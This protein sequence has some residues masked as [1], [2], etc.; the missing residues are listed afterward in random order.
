MKSQ[1]KKIFDQQALLNDEEWELFSQHL[2][3][4][5]FEKGEVILDQ[6]Q[7]E[8]Y[9][10]F[11][12]HGTARMFTVDEF[13]NEFS[14]EFP[15]DNCFCCSYGSFVTQR[16]SMI[17]VEALEPIKAYRISYKDLQF[18]YNK[19][20]TGERLGRINAE[21]FL[22]HK[23]QREIML[24]TLNAKQRY[25][26]LINNNPKILRLVKLEHIATYLGITPQSLSRIRNNIRI[27]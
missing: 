2:S 16:P 18:L 22:A 7:I 1:I 15:S 26:S 6:G 12:I 19:S 8:Q 24:L 14:I 9:L 4:A 10:T 17:A 11:I 25:L 27:N 13:M 23:E 21:L 20:H 5:H 3:E